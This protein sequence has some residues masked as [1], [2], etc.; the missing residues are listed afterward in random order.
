M[1]KGPIITDETRDVI[2]K[3]YLDHRDWRAKEGE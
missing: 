1:A 3:I 2:T